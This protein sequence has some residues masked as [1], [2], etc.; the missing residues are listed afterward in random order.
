MI[1]KI[2]HIKA[3]EQ[4]DFVAKIGGIVDLMEQEG[5]KVDIQYSYSNETY[6]ALIIGR[7]EKKQNANGSRKTV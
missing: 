7:K 5:L 1:E 3:Y 4:T 6:T 2:Q